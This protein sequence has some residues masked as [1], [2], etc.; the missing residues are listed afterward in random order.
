MKFWCNRCKKQIELENYETKSIPFISKAKKIF[1][2]K[3]RYIATSTCKCGTSVSKFI[4]KEDVK[5][6]D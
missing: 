6:D 1:P 2:D 4:K 5:N 3:Q